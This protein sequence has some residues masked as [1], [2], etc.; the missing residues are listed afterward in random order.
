MR[1]KKKANEFHITVN[2]QKLE[3]IK[4]RDGQTYVVM[5]LFS[6]VSY[7]VEFREEIKGHGA[8]EYVYQKWPVCPYEV[9]C[10]NPSGKIQKAELFVDG[11]KVGNKHIHPSQK[12]VFKG[13]S[14]DG[15]VHELLFSLP[16]FATLKE[17]SGGS[18][19]ELKESRANDIGTVKLV[20]QE[21]VAIHS[22]TEHNYKPFIAKNFIQA[23]KVDANAT[24]GG[25]AGNGNSSAKSH[26][27]TT[28]AG[29]V[30]KLIKPHTTTVTYYKQ[31][32]ERTEARLLYRTQHHLE[33]IGVL[34]KKETAAES[35]ERKIKRERRRKRAKLQHGSSYASPVLVEDMKEAG[36]S[37]ALADD[38]KPNGPP[39]EPTDDEEARKRLDKRRRMRDENGHGEFF[40]VVG[41]T[42]LDEIR[43]NG[44]VY[45]IMPIFH[46]EAYGVDFE[47]EIKGHGEIELITQKW[48][49]CPY[50]VAVKNHTDK[51][52]FAILYVDGQKV[53]T[54]Y[55]AAQGS[56]TFEGIPTEEGIQE[57]LFSL[58]RFAT[59]KEKAI[60]GRALP[61]D[62]TSDLGT[63]KVVWRDCVKTGKT[64]EDNYRSYGTSSFKQANKEDA[65]A[66]GGG[67]GS[68]G[69]DKAFA[70]TTRAGKVVG[71]NEGRAC[72]VTNYQFVG[73]PWEAR[74]LYRT[75][76]YLEDTRVIEKKLTEEEWKDRKAKR[77]RRRARRKATDEAEQ[78]G[79]F[80]PTAVNVDAQVPFD[81]QQEG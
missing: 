13:I 73:E 55:V 67:A 62:K 57:L 39:P 23:N 61:S 14:M 75:Q 76:Q 71:L 10:W 44:H 59:L 54:K 68:G 27:S 18:G 12:H 81:E 4:A 30:I 58:P 69:G 38:V 35:A 19:A 9:V 77:A 66:T 49:V 79:A 60:G 63:I 46:K 43:H 42:K 56:I 53:A 21:A 40:V 8:V 74:V 52:H 2:G 11:Q 15:G 45:I 51:G 70:S 25:A 34:E 24:G 3:E 41:D 22:R 65:K 6:K 50:R 80:V 48:P 7:G 64:F 33:E 17:K 32:G 36:P 16:R 78:G 29:K 5:P 37:P 1:D 47:E 31:V 72:T 20:W 26:A 28:R